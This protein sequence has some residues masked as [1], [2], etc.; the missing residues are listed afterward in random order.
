M[1]D[2]QQNEYFFGRYQR[3]NFNPNK[4]RVGV[5]LLIDLDHWSDYVE[6][7]WWIDES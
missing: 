7:E 5:K 4:V 1:N 6:C 2:L 3:K